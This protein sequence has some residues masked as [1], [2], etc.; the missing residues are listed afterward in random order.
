MPKITGG[1][2]VAR[3]LKAEGVEAIFTLSGGHIMS[4]YDGC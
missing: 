1:Q 3:A 4:I 2:L